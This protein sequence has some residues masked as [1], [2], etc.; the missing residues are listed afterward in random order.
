MSRLHV[1][2]DSGN[3]SGCQLCSVMCAAKHY[4][5]FNPKHG[6]IQLVKEEPDVDLPLVC[7]QCEKPDCVEACP[8]V[9]TALN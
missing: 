1:K 3:C 9:Q 5:S 7:R 8:V 2:Y 4:Q 6:R